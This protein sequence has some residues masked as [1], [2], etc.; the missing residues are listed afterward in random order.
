MLILPALG[1]FGSSDASVTVDPATQTV[2]GSVTSG[3][4]CGNKVL[5]GNPDRTSYYTLYFV[6]KF[7]APFTAY[8]TWQDATVNP[9]APSA[10]GGTSYAGGSS[11]GI[12]SPGG[13]PTPGK[14]SG[15][16]VQ[17]DTTSNQQVGVRV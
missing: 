5:D 2:S 8:G 13:Y 10:S 6:A 1:L 14:G 12:T 16:Y 11:G 4:F 15:A 3:N 9:G 7:D 17:F